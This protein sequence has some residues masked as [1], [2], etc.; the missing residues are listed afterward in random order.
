MFLFVYVN[1][2]NSKEDIYTPGLVGMAFVLLK[3]PQYC[4]L[5]IMGITFLENILKARHQLSSGVLQNL[6]EFLF[7]DQEA[8]QYGGNRINPKNS[9]VRRK[10][11][12]RSIFITECLTRLSLSQPML[13]SENVNQIKE[14]ID[15]FLQVSLVNLY[16]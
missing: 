15:F 1:I 3:T 13:I 7:A 14:M 4:S 9:R 5:N 8:P 16:H 6:Q 10:C 11:L 12:K 2:V